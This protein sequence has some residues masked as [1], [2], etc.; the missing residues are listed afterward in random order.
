M[1]CTLRERL[2]TN[3]EAIRMAGS[4]GSPA[5]KEPAARERPES[6]RPKRS[7]LGCSL[8]PRSDKK[9]EEPKA[10]ESAVSSFKNNPFLVADKKKTT[11]KLPQSPRAKAAEARHVA[12]QVSNTAPPAAL[13][14]RQREQL[15]KYRET[16]RQQKQQPARG[17]LTETQKQQLQTLQQQHEPDGTAEA[18]VAA[19]GTAAEAI[20]ASEAGAQKVEAG[21]AQGDAEKTA[22]VVTGD[23]SPEAKPAES[24]EERRA[25]VELAVAA[26]RAEAA[27]KEQ[28]AAE[29]AAQAQADAEDPHLARDL[30][31]AALHFADADLAATAFR[32]L[33]QIDFD[34]EFKLAKEAEEASESLA[35]VVRRERRAAAA[36]GSKRR[37]R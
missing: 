21:A 15:A 32:L 13:T 4:P 3:V 37:R 2:Q 5:P 7:R 36:A 19:A 11:T 28:A 31:A 22:D 25:R 27:A 20:V 35:D 6:H 33:A 9:A 16:Q 29:E 30:A 14:A 8:P 26:A 12:R 24:L 17:P 10:V 34:S 18:A 23:P 1:S